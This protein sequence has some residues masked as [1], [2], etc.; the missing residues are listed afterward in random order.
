MKAMK[1][2][3]SMKFNGFK[4]TSGIMV[5]WHFFRFASAQMV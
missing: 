1:E 2:H 3:I 5:V 4:V